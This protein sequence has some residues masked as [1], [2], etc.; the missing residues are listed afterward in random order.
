M[1]IIEFIILFLKAKEEIKDQI[2]ALIESQL[3]NES[4]E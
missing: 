4:Q 1:N 2:L 3:Q